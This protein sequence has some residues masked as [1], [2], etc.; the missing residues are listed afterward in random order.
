PRV[1]GQL[2]VADAL[3]PLGALVAQSLQAPHAPLVARPPGFDA[4]ADPNFFL[5]PELIEL[6]PRHGLGGK[7]V[8]LARFV[9]GEVAGIRSQQA[10]I[11]LDDAGRDAIE[12]GA[13]V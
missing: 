6:A 3:A 4:L 11:E 2:D 9:R 7:L 8:R 12:K 13:I 5:G 10:A 1:D